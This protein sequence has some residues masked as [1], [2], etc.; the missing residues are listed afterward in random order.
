[1]RRPNALT[2]VTTIVLLAA[3]TLPA[4]Q[5]SGAAG[6]G[7]GS[8]APAVVSATCAD[9]QVGACPAGALLRIKGDGLARARK[10]SFVSLR[11]AKRTRDAR[12]TKASPHRIVV[13]V[14]K[15]ARSGKIK[16]VVGDRAIPGPYLKVLK[17]PAPPAA[18]KTVPADAPLEGGGAGA[19]MVALDG[20]T[21][22]P[23]KGRYSFGTF[24]NG[25][26]GGR[27]HQGQDVLADC[28]TPLVAAFAGTVYINKFQSRA[29]NYLVIDAADGTS[30]AYMHLRELSPLKRGA[31]VA[32]GD[33]IG[34]V[35]RTGDAS[36]CHLH[37]EQ[38]SAPG[39]YQGGSPQDPLP[40]LKRLAGARDAAAR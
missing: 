6:G 14:P 21:A 24:V 33:P 4:T 38:W 16:V 5:A 22:F 36:A 23:V 12:P 19:T 29:G 3:A 13:T 17:L 40:L 2:S 1:M 31:T 18:A 7:A 37:F 11:G 32:A 26:G 15:N 10:V 8:G 35:G 39:W 9:G 28:G 30:Q 25:F 20:A 27:G 34:V